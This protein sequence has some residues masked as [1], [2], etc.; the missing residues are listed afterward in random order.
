MVGSRKQ[1]AFRSHRGSTSFRLVRKEWTMERVELLERIMQTLK[2]RGKVLKS[3]F[4][5]LSQL[6]E[7]S[8]ALNSTEWK[9]WKRLN[10]G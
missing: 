5:L 10:G 1:T 2:V 3:L 7:L 6:K 8:I 9:G 4:G